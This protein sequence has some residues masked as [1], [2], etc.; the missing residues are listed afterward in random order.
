MRGCRRAAA[1]AGRCY[2][3]DTMSA[4]PKPPQVSSPAR[5]AVPPLENGDR[6]TRAE[7]ERRYRAMPEVKKAELIEG[8]VYMPSPVRIQRHAKPHLIMATWLG[9]YLAKTPGLSTFGDNGTVRLDEDNEPQPDLFLLLPGSVGGAAKVDEDD[10]V[11][12][13]PALVCEVSASSVSIDLHSKMNAYRRNGVREYLSWRTE[14]GAVDWFALCEGRYEPLP[15]D[16]AQVVRSAQ[17]PGLWL[18]AAALLAGDLPAL[19]KTVDEGTATPDH[20]TF[21][22][23]LAAK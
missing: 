16:A 21:V 12:G 18:N 1:A 3:I 15:R 2:T 22:A 17:F 19:F 5:P 4:I 11:T 10:Y 8:V 9:Y 13:P 6:L 7:F 20:A 14:D 23:R